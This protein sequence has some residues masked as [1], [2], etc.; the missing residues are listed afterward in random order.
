MGSIAAT[1]YIKNIRRNLNEEIGEDQ[2]IIGGAGQ[3]WTNTG[4][5]EYL[6]KAKDRCWSIVRKAR[7]DYFETTG[8]TG[9]T[10][11][12]TTKEYTLPSGFRQLVGIKI[13]QSGYESLKLRRVEQSQEEFK[14]RDALPSGNESDDLIYDIIGVN[15]IKFADF[16]PTTLTTSVD[17][18]GTVADFTLSASSTLAAINDE[19]KEFI[20][21]YATWLALGKNPEDKRLAFWGAEVTRLSPETILNVSQRNL[22]DAKYVEPYDPS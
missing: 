2:L 3:N 10:L 14:R 21:A 13:T 8:D 6:N 19:W 4:L 22:R 17:Y 15:T 16:P 9:I 12:S 7:E 18:I 11:N 20:E 1:T 5:L